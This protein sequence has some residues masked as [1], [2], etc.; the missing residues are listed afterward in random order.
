[1][2]CGSFLAHDAVYPSLNGEASVRNDNEA[3]RERW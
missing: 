3:A 1:M 2:C